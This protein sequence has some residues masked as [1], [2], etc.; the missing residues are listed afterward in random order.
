[1]KKF[2]SL[3]LATL[4]VLSL[5][6]CG[7]KQ[8]DHQGPQNPSQ[9]IVPQDLVMG[10]GSTGGTYFALGGAMANA[11]NDKLADKKITITA[12]STGASV[13]NMNLINA[14]EMDLGIAM[15][16]V[17]ANAFDGVG[18]F[19]SP[20]TNVS[21]I[22]VVYNEVYQIVANAATGAK[23]V[24]DLKGKK[25]AIGPAGSGTLG[26]SQKIF[27]AA[28]LDP[29][30]DIQPQS[31]SFGDAATKMQDGHIDAACNVLAVPASS[32]IEMT[33][34]MKL[35]YVNISDDI[36]ETLQ[37]TE[38]YF[39]RKVIPAGT[40]DGQTE[41]I[42]TSTCKAALYCR[43]DLDEETVYQITKAF[44]ESGDVIAA[45]HATGKEVQ[46]EGC[47]EGITTPI[48]PGAARYYKEM[49]ITVPDNG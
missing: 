19:S 38:P 12:Q 42:N 48:H 29:N 2:L 16:N 41:D 17:A 20:V 47:L 22:G 6:A 44:Y 21:S 27:T 14:G 4:L 36:L 45:A 25:V 49:G 5:A 28:G 43:A 40:Y 35:A 18:A 24:E 39:V 9:T 23:N 15:N 30:K 31:D 33:T 10:T 7:E 34:S 1:M 11:I 26:L 3:L 46:L 8:Q 13:E 32:I 37:A